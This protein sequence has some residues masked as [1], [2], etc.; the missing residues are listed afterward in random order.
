MSSFDQSTRFSF[1]WCS[2]DRYSKN[3]NGISFWKQYN[4]FQLLLRFFLYSFSK[5][6][7][8]SKER[9]RW[10]Y[11]C[12][13]SKSS[14]EQHWIS[15]LE[16][17]GKIICEDCIFRSRG[18]LLNLINYI[19]ALIFL[20]KQNSRIEALP[21]EKF[22]IFYDDCTYIIYA[23]TIKGNIVNQYTIVSYSN[24]ITSERVTKQK[25]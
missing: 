8:W 2:D 16:S 17:W 24:I 11:R 25:K 9:S 23:S 10:C 19:F 22:G 6:L 21:K 13:I 4:S 1:R 12:G 3:W 18:T 20:I 7:G 5:Y 14:K 15:H